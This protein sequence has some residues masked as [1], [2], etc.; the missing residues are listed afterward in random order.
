[1][2]REFKLLFARLVEI[3][4]H[5]FFLAGLMTAVEKGQGSKQAL[6]LQPNR[7]G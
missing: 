2:P 3:Y 5:G 6:I 1:M 4:Y 7:L